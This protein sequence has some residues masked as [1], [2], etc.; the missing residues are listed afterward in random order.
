MNINFSCRQATIIL[1]IL[2]VYSINAIAGTNKLL[3]NI[4]I[5]SLKIYHMVFNDQH[6]LR[7]KSNGE[8]VYEENLLFEPFTDA[9]R[10]PI[11][12][13]KDEDNK[14]ILLI[15]NF[16]GGASCCFEVYLFSLDE[17]KYTD[18]LITY[19]DLIQ[20]KNIN[21]QSQKQIF[22][23]S[24]YENFKQIEG[25][26]PPAIYYKI[27]NG[28]FI[29]IKGGDYKEFYIKEAKKLEELI[30]SN[31]TN[32]NYIVEFYKMWKTTIERSGI[33]ASISSLDEYIEIINNCMKD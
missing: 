19:K 13:F 17:M 7:I 3:Q 23:S 21:E 22:L 15:E 16:S 14:P 33:T 28:K 9:S 2:L 5:D 4:N 30:I 20:F 26:S 11:S 32:C 12:L 24:D 27:K 8:K 25:W 6:I 18:T 10:E 1:S 31:I 29:I